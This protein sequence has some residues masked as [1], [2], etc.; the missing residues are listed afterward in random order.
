MVYNKKCQD[1]VFNGGSND[2]QMMQ[3]EYHAQVPSHPVGRGIF[4][5]AVRV[6]P[7]GFPREFLYTSYVYAPLYSTK[8]HLEIEFFNE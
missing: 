5:R 3:N 8:I 2:V 7:P 4:A 1:R 6:I